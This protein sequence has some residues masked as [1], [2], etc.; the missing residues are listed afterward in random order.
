MRAK[1]KARMVEFRYEGKKARAGKVE[2]GRKNAID[3]Q[4][5]EKDVNKIA[6]KLFKESRLMSLK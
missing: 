2:K 6:E 5:I 1:G 3:L 4:K